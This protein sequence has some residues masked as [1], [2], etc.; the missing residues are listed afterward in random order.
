MEGYGSTESTGS[1]L[2]TSGTDPVTGHVGG[3][4]AN[5]EF[6]LVDVKELGY[7]SKDHNEKG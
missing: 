7:S 4:T 6:K 2:V 5:T 3:T 1:N